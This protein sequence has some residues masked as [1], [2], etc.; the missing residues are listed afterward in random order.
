MSFSNP[1]FIIAVVGVV[2]LYH[3]ELITALLNLAQFR[4]PLPP[5]IRALYDPEKLERCQDYH[6]QSTTLDVLR[7][8]ASVVLLIVFWWSGGFVWLHQTVSNLGWSSVS[9]GVLTLLALFA[10][11]SLLALPF[12]LWSTFRIESAFGFNRTTVRTF[13]SDRIKGALLGLLLGTPL[14]A[15]IL[16]FFET[17]RWAAL[18]AWTTLTLFSLLMAWISPRFIMPLFLKFEPL[19]DGPLKK[20]IFTLAERLHFPIAEV[21]LVDGSRRSSKANAFFA[22]FGKTKRIALF[23]TLVANH[24]EDEVLAVLAHEIGHNKRR[25]I[26]KTML[27][28]LLE[29]ALLFGCLHFALNSP[30][31][32]AA[33]GLTSQPIALGLVFFSIVYKPVSFLLTLGSSQLSRQHEFEAD[34][35]AR[36]AMG[37]HAPLTA[38]LTRLSSDHLAHP[39]PHPLAVRLYYSH[40]PLVERLGALQQSAP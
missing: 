23:D 18:Y 22:G 16:W 32:F 29:S 14:L 11:Q 10:V 2:I 19:P 35:Y 13:I 38:A 27:I 1:W 9:S 36:E 31:L 24:T 6:R 25:H 21:S 17:Q 28:G 7:D 15:L 39:Q 26:P 33:F 5:S 34:A 3:L 37:G 8:T 20:A 12:D 4:K 30:A 40:P